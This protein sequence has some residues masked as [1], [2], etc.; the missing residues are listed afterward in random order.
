MCPSDLRSRLPRLAYDYALN[1]E[2]VREVFIKVSR[3]VQIGRFEIKL[4]SLC[5]LV[6]FRDSIAG[7]SVSLKFLCSALRRDV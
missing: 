5:T 1:A 7:L 2:Y 3:Y 4:L 6:H